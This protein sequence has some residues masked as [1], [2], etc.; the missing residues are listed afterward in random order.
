MKTSRRDEGKFGFAIIG[1]INIHVIHHYDYQR[2]T[3]SV[4]PSELAKWR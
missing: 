1:I 2:L 3:L 4:L